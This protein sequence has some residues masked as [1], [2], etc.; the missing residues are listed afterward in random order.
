MSGGRR[1]GRTPRERDAEKCW[2]E[3][4]SG[5]SCAEATGC[6]TWV[7]A[8]GHER[9]F[10]G[11]DGHG[12]VHGRARP[13]G[14]DGQVHLLGHRHHHRGASGGERRRGVCQG[15]GGGFPERG[16]PGLRPGDTVVGRAWAEAGLVE[17]LRCVRRSRDLKLQVLLEAERSPVACEIRCLLFATDDRYE[18]AV[19]RRASGTSST[20]MRRRMPSGCYPFRGALVRQ[21]VRRHGRGHRVG[22]QELGEDADRHGGLARHGAQGYI[23]TVVERSGGSGQE[24]APGGRRPSG[25]ARGAAGEKEAP[26]CAGRCDR[27]VGTRRRRRRHHLQRRQHHPRVHRQQPSQV[28]EVEGKGERGRNRMGLILSC[29]A[30]HQKQTLRWSSRIILFLVIKYRSSYFVG[31]TFRHQCWASPTAVMIF[32]NTARGCKW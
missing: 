10:R 21:D 24:A 9:V 31:A 25:K 27:A 13:G 30:G 12:E 6:G 20:S 23:R 32:S 17:L 1:Y 4:G 14:R 26:V 3:H 22:E 19:E 11:H 16:E 7:E 5:A 28:A 29:F 8:P 15:R 18:T 2:A